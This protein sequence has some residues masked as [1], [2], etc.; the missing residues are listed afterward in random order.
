MK[1]NYVSI[2]IAESIQRCGNGTWSRMQSFTSKI[3]TKF[4]S[5]VH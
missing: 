5:M 2:Q 4:T 3:P 1:D